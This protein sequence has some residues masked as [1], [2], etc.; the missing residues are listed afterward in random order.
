[1]KTIQF[2]EKGERV[3]IEMIIDTVALENG[4]V[5]YKLKDPRSLKEY[6]HIFCN[7]ELFA[8][9]KKEGEEWD[10]SKEKSSDS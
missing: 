10:E 9:E 5:V 2:F 4:K 7:D 3:G 6:P 8:L 1:M